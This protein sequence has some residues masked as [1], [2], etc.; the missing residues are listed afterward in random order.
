LENYAV[1]FSDYEGGATIDTYLAHRAA[2]RDMELIVFHALVPSYDLS[3]DDMKSIP[4]P[5]TRTIRRGTTSSCASTTCST[6]A[7]T[8]TTWESAPPR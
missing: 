5:S 6:S 3:Q 4:S 7:W 8:Y 1:R 2:K